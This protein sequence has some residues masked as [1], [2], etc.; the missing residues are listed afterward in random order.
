[1]IQAGFLWNMPSCSQQSIVPSL[2]SEK[3]TRA[4]KCHDLLV[5][6]SKH[7]ALKPKC[8][9]VQKIEK[10][11]RINQDPMTTVNQNKQCQTCS[12]SLAHQFLLHTNKINPL[13]NSD[14]APFQERFS[15]S[16]LASRTEPVN[17]MLSSQFLPE[18]QTVPFGP[19]GNLNEFLVRY[20]CLLVA[21]YIILKL[22]SASSWSKQQENEKRDIIMRSP[23]NKQNKQLLRDD[24]LC[25]CFCMRRPCFRL[26]NFQL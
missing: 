11:Q 26:S 2:K 15:G 25:F 24:G 14:A 3:R 23:N 16:S 4:K 1:M 19:F 5:I 21:E 8:L 6:V 22:C 10:D 12:Y 20:A 18:W 13:A 17:A 7:A 9:T